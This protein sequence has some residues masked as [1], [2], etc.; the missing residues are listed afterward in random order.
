MC[1][2]IVKFC[3]V[4]EFADANLWF[5]TI[6]PNIFIGTTTKTHGRKSQAPYT[7]QQS[8]HLSLASLISLRNTIY[9]RFS[10][11]ANTASVTRVH[12]LFCNSGFLWSSA[13]SGWETKVNLDVVVDEPLK[14]RMISL[15]LEV[16]D[17]YAV[18]V[19]IMMIRV[20][21]PDHRP[22]KPICL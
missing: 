14:T 5:H 1:F 6:K 22:P 13:T 11:V 21:S 12:S 8:W 20:P 4:Y 7:L 9:F 16:N 19:P 18:R 15:A 17:T 10:L 2:I 3:K